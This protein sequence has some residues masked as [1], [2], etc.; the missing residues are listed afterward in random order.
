MHQNN[1]TS[2]ISSSPLQILKQ[3][4]LSMNDNNEYPFILKEDGND[5]VASWNIVDAK[6]VEMFGKAGLKKQFELRLIFDEANKTVKYKEKS[7]DVEWDANTNTIKLKKS[8]RYGKCLEFNSG[9]SWGVKEDGSVGKIYDYK[10][11]TTEITDPVFDIIQKAGWKV[12]LSLL[13][14]K[15]SR[16]AILYTVVPLAIL[17]FIFLA[18]LFF[19]SMS[20]V[21]DAARVEID[22]LRNGH[23][24]EAY[25]ASSSGLQEILSSSDFDKAIQSENFSEIKDY[26]FNSISIKNDQA[27]LKGSVSYNDGSDGDIILLMKKENDKWKL[28]SFKLS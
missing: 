8:V 27:Y 1:I 19:S 17:A 23:I 26:S 18:V 12:N 28:L 3:Q 20:G 11:N 6:W 24:T 13:D 15:G 7:S 16:K 9:S 25:E 2:A 21:K 5:I 14:K 22:L 4:L 10:F